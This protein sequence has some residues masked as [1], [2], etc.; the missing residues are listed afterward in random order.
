M[1]DIWSSDLR[2]VWTSGS[3]WIHEWSNRE[4]WWTAKEDPL[5]SSLTKHFKTQASF[6]CNADLKKKKK[7]KKW[8]PLLESAYLIKKETLFVIS[9]ITANIYSKQFDRKKEEL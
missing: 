5:H 2:D 3:C 6:I 7:K 1:N 8:H 9:T 4:S